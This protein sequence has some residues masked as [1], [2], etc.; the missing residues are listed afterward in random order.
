MRGEIGVKNRPENL[1]SSKDHGDHPFKKLL[2]H[3]VLS[4]IDSGAART[5]G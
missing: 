3:S 4:M 5:P 2:C 1:A